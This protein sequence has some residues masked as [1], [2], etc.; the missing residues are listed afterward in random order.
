MPVTFPRALPAI[1]RFDSCELD[2]VEVQ[3]GQRDGQGAT[4]P[5]PW[6]E[7]FWRFQARTPKLSREHMDIWDA[8]RTSLRGA[9]GTFWAVDPD[10][11]F[12]RAYMLTGWAGLVRAT[13]ATGA[14]AFNGN[15]FLGSVDSSRT[16]ILL[17][18]TSAAAN[19]AQA[20][21]ALFDVRPGDLLNID[22][23]AGASGEP[24]RS[25][26]RVVNLETPTTSF[27]QLVV[28][29]QPPV[30]PDSAV[31]ST[32]RFQDPAAKCRATEIGLTKSATGGQVRPGMVTINAIEELVL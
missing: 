32:V 7:P 16:V 27:G 20:L 13:Y 31:G 19:Q 10:K 1:A 28:Q 5:V 23:P 17:G 30:V 22:R 21:P 12:P 14:P 8:W 6:G 4:A 15:T 9:S 24:R 29:I 3:S 2:L 18:A 26:H 11:R 25:L